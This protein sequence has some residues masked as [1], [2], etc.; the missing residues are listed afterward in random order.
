LK[1]QDLMTRE[2]ARAALVGWG[3]TFGGD[4]GGVVLALAVGAKPVDPAVAGEQLRREHGA[5]AEYAVGVF[6]G[7]GDHKGREK[8]VLVEMAVATG[9]TLA[10]LLAML[11]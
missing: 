8:R 1:A 10:R 9:T 5:A 2:P 7:A 6:V 11:G 4:V 3:G